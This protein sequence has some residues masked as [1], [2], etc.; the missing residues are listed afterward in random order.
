[1]ANDGDQE[2]MVARERDASRLAEELDDAHRIIDRMCDAVLGFRRPDWSN[3]Y[4]FEHAV[5]A[6]EYR[7]A[8]LTEEGKRPKGR[9]IARIGDMSPTDALRVGFDNEGDICLSTT[10]PLEGVEFCTTGSGGGKSPKTRAALI[11]LMVAMEEDNAQDAS[12]DWWAMRNKKTSGESQNH[13]PT[14]TQ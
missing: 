8:T 12:R 10:N 1:M 2:A 3:S 4:G 7:M 13:A 14:D 6:I 11:A 5:R 9:E